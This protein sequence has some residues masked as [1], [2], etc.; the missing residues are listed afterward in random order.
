MKKASTAAVKATKNFSQPK[1]TIGLDLG[2]RIELVLE[3][4]PPSLVCAGR[5]VFAG[6]E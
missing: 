1:L 2:N 4:G 6:W 3:N 5:T